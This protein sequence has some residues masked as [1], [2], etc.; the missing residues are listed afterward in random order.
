MNEV[1]D[2]G[3]AGRKCLRKGK[4]MLKKEKGE[5]FPPRHV[6]TYNPIHISVL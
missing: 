1:K 2:Q 6:I 5:T 3:N 4:A